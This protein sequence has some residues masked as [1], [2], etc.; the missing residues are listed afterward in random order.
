MKCYK[1]FISCFFVIL[2]STSNWLTAQTIT[3]SS[4]D[5]FDTEKG[6]LRFLA[7]RYNYFYFIKQLNNRVETIV[8]DTLMDKKAIIELDFVRPSLNSFVMLGSRDGFQCFYE[9]HD[10]KGTRV[11]N[12]VFLNDYMRTQGRG[13]PVDTIDQDWKMEWWETSA[14]EEYTVAVFSKPYRRKEDITYV[15]KFYDK[16]GHYLK[17]AE[18]SQYN[19]LQKENIELSNAGRLYLVAD[20]REP[21]PY[22]VRTFGIDSERW[23]E[24]SISQ[25]AITVNKP[26]FHINPINDRVYFVI[27]AGV[28][29]ERKR[30]KRAFLYG[31]IDT[32]GKAISKLSS[33][34]NNE[35]LKGLFDR[36]KSFKIRYIN[37]TEQGGLLVAM[38]EFDE[39][40]TRV[41]MNS[42]FTRGGTFSRMETVYIL[43]DIHLILLDKD[44]SLIWNK[45]FEKE[46]RSHNEISPTA[47]FG[48]INRGNNISLYYNH[49]ENKKRVLK[50]WTIYPN[51]Q[52]REDFFIWKNAKTDYNFL[53]LYG[54]QISRSESILPVFSGGKLGLAKLNMEK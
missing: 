44:G 16:E 2:L 51:G 22:S 39:E 3:S 17:S 45:Q 52:S 38:E 10:K 26:F 29:G 50:G 43:G 27:D 11:I 9:D 14:S 47:S 18:Y 24:I 42:G 25:T 46:Q 49:V 31:Y 19:T 7:K 37:P 28:E 6:A 48:L 33:G 23:Q 36:E 30:L 53:V 13:K 41:V 34:E 12:T 15:F 32:H 40:N 1:I 54:A 8:Y 20:Q 4:F 21:S 35:Y 5:D